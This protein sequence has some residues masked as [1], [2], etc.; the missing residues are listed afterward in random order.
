MLGLG[1]ATIQPIGRVLRCLVA[2]LVLLAPFGA[3]AVAQESWIT[4]PVDGSAFPS[5][6][7][8]EDRQPAIDGLP[9]G[10]VATH[11]GEITSA[12]YAVPTTRYG[13]GILGDAVEAATLMVRTRD[14]ET[15]SL[16]LPQTEVFEDR[17][18]RLADLDGDGLTEVI[19]IRASVTE[20]AAVTIYGLSDGTLVR[21]ASTDF[22]GRAN[23]WLNIAGIADFRGTGKQDIAFVRT[24]HIGG[25]LF[26][27]AFENGDLVRKAAMDG[28]SNHLIGATEMRLSAIA[29]VDGD[30]RQ[31]LAV[32][33][34]SRRTLRIVGFDAAG[35][36]VEPGTAEL[37]AP[38][39]K[40]IAVQ[41]SG[42]DLRFVVGL[43]DGSV[44]EVRRR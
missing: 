23:R 14:G 29:D 6:I 30:G 41:G 20:G 19:T 32:P 40:A 37:P 24:P 28:F 42:P 43:A 26:V 44:H 39:D 34:N 7:V 8:A 25:T 27:Y 9:D 2:P 5:E 4:Q 33:S 12:W 35:S 16:S 31:D 13:H 38:I 3:T 18:P 11:D 17:A 10:L 36:L 15:L 1:R 22:I 21:R